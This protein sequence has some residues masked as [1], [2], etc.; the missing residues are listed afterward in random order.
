MARKTHFEDLSPTQQRR[1][2]R[3]GIT[4]AQYERGVSLQAARGHKPREHVTRRERNPQGLT[5]ND[6]R[7]LKQQKARAGKHDFSMEI[8]AF[9]VLDVDERKDFWRRVDADYREYKRQG[10]RSGIVHGTI[11]DLFL[12]YRDIFPTFPRDAVALAFYH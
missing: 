2:I 11:E 12:H 9:R 4:K 7:R 6:Y 5:S 1:Y 8:A 10:Y 3:Y